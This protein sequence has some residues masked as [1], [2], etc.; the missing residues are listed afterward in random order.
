[1][2]QLKFS[3]NPNGKLFSDIFGDIRLA[4]YEK[5]Q[6]GNIIEIKLKKDVI[7]KVKVIGAKDFSFVRLTDTIAHMNCGREASY[8]AR[9]LKSFYEG[10]GDDSQLMHIVFK[11]VTRNMELQEAL[12]ADWWQAKRDQFTTDINSF[13]QP[14]SNE[15]SWAT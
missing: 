8:Q 2:L 6:A 9:M 7:G 3:T 13:H 14:E 10:I 15:F 1:M 5:F 12:M 11:W 4:D